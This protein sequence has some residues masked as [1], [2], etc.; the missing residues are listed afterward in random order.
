MKTF[1]APFV[2][3][4]VILGFTVSVSADTLPFDWN[5]PENA[6]VFASQVAT[7]S[8]GQRPVEIDYAIKDNVLYSRI[9]FTS[10]TDAQAHVEWISQGLN[11]FGGNE[12]AT[13]D[14]Q[15]H[16]FYNKNS[17]FW[18]DYKYAVD[19]DNV[20]VVGIDIYEQGDSSAG[21]QYFKANTFTTKHLTD[22]ARENFLDYLEA[23]PSTDTF[24]RM[25]AEAEY[26]YG[27][28]H[29]LNY[30]AGDGN[31]ESFGYGRTDYDGKVSATYSDEQLSVF[32]GNEFISSFNTYDTYLEYAVNLDGLGLEHYNGIH[33]GSQLEG[34]YTFLE[35]P[36]AN[37]ATPEPATALIL[38]FAG[39]LALPFLRRKTKSVKN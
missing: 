14:S 3:A 17:D 1:F 11:I 28:S 2:F 13:G 19:N 6:T 18:R 26:T 20:Y 5:N 21:D 30:W 38:G 32:I 15:E 7:F 29:G 25:N 33:I 16:E 36:S 31:A 37:A 39:C 9:N 10:E 12:R 8:Y 4:A 35:F 22:A 34:Y 24:I 27:Y 23:L